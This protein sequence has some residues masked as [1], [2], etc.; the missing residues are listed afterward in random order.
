MPV[1]RVT[2]RTGRT[3]YGYHM[4]DVEAPDLREAMAIAA[5]RLPEKVAATA[6]VAEVRLLVDP[7]RRGLPPE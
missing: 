7:E 6:E 2:V 4:E 1:F 5:G 3:R